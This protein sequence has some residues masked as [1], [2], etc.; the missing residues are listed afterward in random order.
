[1]PNRK[2]TELAK[3]G[4]KIPT[5]L[6]TQEAPRTSLAEMD[7][8]SDQEM[9][10]I[11][12]EIAAGFAGTFNDYL[13]NGQPKYEWQ[14]HL[15]GG[16]TIARMSEVMTGLGFAEFV[17]L[18]FR[19]HRPTLPFALG[20]IHWKGSVMG[21]WYHIEF[22]RTALFRDDVYP[23]DAHYDVDRPSYIFHRTATGKRKPPTDQGSA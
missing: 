11:F 21:N 1:M 6:A 19:S 22:R 15:P 9:E 20:G 16:I 10:A 7:A 5:P 8:P 18:N 13:V 2:L 14:F 3:L 12:E 4:I 23:V 17:N